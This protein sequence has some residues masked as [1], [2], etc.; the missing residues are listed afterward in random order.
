MAFHRRDL[1]KGIVAV[2]ILGAARQLEALVPQNIAP[3]VQG[4]ALNIIFKGAFG[5]IAHKKR[6][7][8]LA[9]APKRN[10]HLHYGAGRKLDEK[11]CYSFRMNE[12]P[13]GQ[14]NLRYDDIFDDYK[15]ED[16]TAPLQYGMSFDL[17]L[18]SAIRVWHWRMVRTN[19]KDPEKMPLDLVLTYKITADQLAAPGKVALVS[20]WPAAE[21]LVPKRNGQLN[22]LNLILQ[23]G[24]DMNLPNQEEHAK[25][26]TAQIVNEA[27]GNPKKLE[28]LEF[29]QKEGVENIPGVPEVSILADNV[30]CTA[31]PGGGCPPTGCG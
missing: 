1:L 24:P 29:I 30:G 27:T 12:E 19:R 26:V 11:L 23:V 31:G 6:G 13:T 14:S 7:R 16:M 20:T 21:T 8:I 9:W 25:A 18:P 15:I 4:P 17:P 22:Y 28:I 5:L 3:Q 10:D 2:P